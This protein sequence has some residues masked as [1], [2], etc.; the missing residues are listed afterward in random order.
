MPDPNSKLIA[1]LA[2]AHAA[3]GA[4]LIELTES[5]PEPTAPVPTA[6]LGGGVCKHRNRKELAPSFGTTEHWVCDDCGFEFRR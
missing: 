5:P 6:A 4:L 1:T 2:A 3:I